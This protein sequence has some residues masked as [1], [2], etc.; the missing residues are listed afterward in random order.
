MRIPK[1]FHNHPVDCG[2]A[3]TPSPAHPI[4]GMFVARIEAATQF[5]GSL[6]LSGHFSV[7]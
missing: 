6:A 7:A 5:N 2:K 3:R 1:T 4:G